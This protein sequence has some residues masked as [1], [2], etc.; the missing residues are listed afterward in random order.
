LDLLKKHI[1]PDTLTMCYALTLQP[2]RAT[3]TACKTLRGINT[4]KMASRNARRIEKLE[5]LLLRVVSRSSVAV[6]PRVTLAGTVRT[7]TGSVR[8]R[9][10]RLLE[11]LLARIAGRRMRS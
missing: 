6:L 8:M 4:R 9:K 2:L 1:S 10:K 3:S 11:S 5:A 7:G